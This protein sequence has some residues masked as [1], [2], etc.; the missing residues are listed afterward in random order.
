MGQISNV[1]C[2]RLR[3]QIHFDIY[4][5]YDIP[6]HFLF[7]HEQL[8]FGSLSSDLVWE[9]LVLMFFALVLVTTWKDVEHPIFDLTS[10]NS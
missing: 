3:L 8:F 9:C 5:K 7:I 1:L 4:A 2:R 10:Q 6:A